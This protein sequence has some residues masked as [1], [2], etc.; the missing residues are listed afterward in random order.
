MSEN[1]L[2]DIS[3]WAD[4]LEGKRQDRWVMEID[5]IPAYLLK[6]AERP[7]GENGTIEVDY[8]N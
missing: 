1:Y 2:A 5:G 7:K 3:K 8:I 6:T 4:S